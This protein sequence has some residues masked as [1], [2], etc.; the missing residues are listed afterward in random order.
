[1]FCGVDEALEMGGDAGKRRRKVLDPIRAL[2]HFGRTPCVMWM[3]KRPYERRFL[4]AAGTCA[5]HEVWLGPVVVV[6][7][8]SSAGRVQNCLCKHTSINSKITERFSSGYRIYG[9]G[10]PLS[11]LN[12]VVLKLNA[13]RMRCNI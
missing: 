7:H 8:Y 13:K 10:L 6:P 5:D 12:L 11:T 4:Q 9:S 1:M 2:T 3:M